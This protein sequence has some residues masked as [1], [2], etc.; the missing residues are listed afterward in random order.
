MKIMSLW[1]D[2]VFKKSLKYSLYKAASLKEA[3][4]LLF[5]LWNL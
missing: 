4:F 1:S 3:A 2:L 5:L